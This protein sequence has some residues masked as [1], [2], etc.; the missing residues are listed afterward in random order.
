MV[1]NILLL[2]SFNQLH[3]QTQQRRTCWLMQYIPTYLPT[4]IHT[5][6]RTWHQI[7]KNNYF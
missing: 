1:Y 2:E 7:T 3:A 5:N 4:Y 6:Q